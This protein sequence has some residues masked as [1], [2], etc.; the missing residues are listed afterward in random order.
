MAFSFGRGS[1]KNYMGNPA[2]GDE[3][4][5]VPENKAIS[6][7]CLR[8]LQKAATIGGNFQ[9]RELV[10][11]VL[12]AQPTKDQNYVRNY[13]SHMHRMGWMQ[14]VSKPLP[15]FG[16]V[17][18]ITDDGLRMIEAA[19]ENDNIVDYRWDGRSR[20]G[21]RKSKTKNVHAKRKCMRC[22]EDFR[23]AHKH[24]HLCSNCTGFAAANTGAFA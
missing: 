22:Q 13:I 4:S 8:V 18:S 24:N 14:L 20:G 6:I 9:S 2:R 3:M 10:D 15:P 19:K 5:L 16:N 17:W 1:A 21:P 23:P 7:M 12:E 11:L